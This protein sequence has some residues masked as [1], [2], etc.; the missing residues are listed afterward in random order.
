MAFWT[1]RMVTDIER[2][3]IMMPVLSPKGAG[4][5]SRR[6]IMWPF[7]KGGLIVLDISGLRPSRS[8]EAPL[9]K[10]HHDPQKE[11]QRGQQRR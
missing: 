3:S 2:P 6:F 5:K 8:T 1:W 7:S 11:D 9:Q 4:L 10:H